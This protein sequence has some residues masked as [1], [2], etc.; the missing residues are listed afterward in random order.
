M[1]KRIN[2]KVELQNV[3]KREMKNR[4]LTINGLARDC[5]IPAATLHAWIHGV[6]PSAKNLHHVATLASFFELPV[7]EL[8]FGISEKNP[9]NTTVFS[10]E[11]ADSGNKYCLSVEKV[12]KSG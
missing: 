8:L 7:S 4:H 6:L 3:L 10:S 2:M 9:T 12:L 11:F 1:P 5:K